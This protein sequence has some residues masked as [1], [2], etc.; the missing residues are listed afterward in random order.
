MRE[1]RSRR[2]S[3]LGSALRSELSG[4]RHVDCVCTNIS[5]RRSPEVIH[6]VRTVRLQIMAVVAKRKGNKSD[7]SKEQVVER[8]SSLDLPR[9]HPFY[10]SF[11]IVIQ[12]AVR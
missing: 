7:C 12:S 6:D 9:C 11:Q 10:P 8:I 3:S 2:F 1:L 4:T 5:I